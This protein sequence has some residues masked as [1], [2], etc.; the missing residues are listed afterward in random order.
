MM[1]TIA[2]GIGLAGAGFLFSQILNLVAYLVLVR[3]L[4]PRDFGLYAAGTLIT[5]IGGL[6]AESGMMAA[7][8]TRED[9]IDEAA[10]TAFVSLAITG[11]ALALGSLAISPLL[12][13]A[14][15]NSQV[16]TVA[17]V[18]SG[19]LLIR[20]LTIV[21]DALLQRRFSFARRA[22]V[23]PLGVVAYAAAAIPLAASG[24]GV[25]AMVGG[26]YASI[27]VEAVFS[28]LAAGFRPRLRHASVSL[29]R[30]LSSFTR[31]LVVGEVLR[32]VTIQIDTF[33]L[34]RVSGPAALGQYRN[35][36]M[37]AQQP[38]NAFG[39]V[40]AYVILPA[41]ARLASVPARL[42]VAA[43]RAFWVTH[44]AVVPVAAACLPL[45]VPVAVILLGTRWR[46]AGHAIAGLSGFVL[47]SILLSVSGELMKAMGALRL[48]LATH[49][50]WL[51]LVATTVVTASL[52]W[53]LVGVAVALSV[54]TCA[55]AVYTMVKIARRM[56]LPGHELLSGLA[57]PAVASAVMVGV[58]LLFSSASNLLHHSGA[59]GIVL[60]LVDTLI[61]AV[62]Y[63]ATLA[64]IDGPRRRAALALLRRLWGRFMAVEPTY[65]RSSATAEQYAEPGSETRDDQPRTAHAAPEG[66]HRIRTLVASPLGRYCLLAALGF[67]L[68][69][70]ETLRATH[71]VGDFW[72]HAATVR[73]LM[74][75]TT[76]PSNALLAVHS[77]SAFFSPYALLVAVAAKATGTGP[78]HELAVAGLLNYCLLAGG[79]WWF[80]RLFSERPQAPFYALLFL[81]LLWGVHPWEYS[82]FFD[83]RELGYGLAYPSTFA[84]AL[85]MLTAALWQRAVWRQGRAR[86]A[87]AAL[88]AVGVALVVLTHPVAGVATL[89]AIGAVSL[90]TDGR[91]SLALLA[92]T[93]VGA[94]V[95]CLI[96]P[97]YPILRLLGDQGVYDPSNEL[98]YQGWIEQTFPVFAAI[99]LFFYRTGSLHRAR[100]AIYCA[101]LLL[102]FIYGDVSGHWSDG[103][104]IAYLVL[105]AQIGLGDAAA[106]WEQRA[107]AH[108][109]R[110]PIFAVA[111]AMAIFAA[112]ELANM[113]DGFRGSLPGTG[114][115]EPVAY[116]GYRSAVN[117]LPP[118]SVTAAPLDS[119]IE[120]VVP[121][122]GG[123]L[124]STLRP[125]AFVADQRQ[126][127]Q[128]VEAFYSAR[129]SN[130]FRRQ[131]IARYH[132]NYVLVP[133]APNQRALASALRQ[134]GP[135]IRRGSMFDTLSV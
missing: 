42:A 44:T 38:G 95:L 75:H 67:I 20:A 41:F 98:M 25:W 73:E 96:W 99:G 116:A 66:Q 43:R 78:V 117:G 119:G 97:Y 59:V 111:M 63:C 70:L 86:L 112:L 109:R 53:G 9:R 68:V 10:S 49:V 118:D 87:L 3:L 121:V 30:E 93:V 65:V 127:Q 85:G 14:F 51:V 125:L 13:L 1:Q 79:V 131:V 54:S 7:L 92:G 115:P 103:R 4:T 90:T 16:G 133:T 17:A 24:A 129:T 135:V 58:M 114:S 33:M 113:A 74:L 2:R 104:E 55:T 91:R 134:L 21:P 77:P 82:G 12:G 126:R 46:A 48:Q 72:E 132:V 83:L 101:P 11:V 36:M 6:F 5:G 29:W 88:T 71:E 130:R 28:W 128:T 76:N 69:A 80:A 100:L 110:L 40:G 57:T 106:T 47:G 64:A 8:I 34:G 35:G 31:P 39:S 102:L 60:L 62:V 23:D 26:A 123:K 107:Q 84:T 56:G 105:G 50:V 122:Y 120:A 124:I 94:G 18:L 52:T 22:V 81:W 108:P 19:W 89:A 27:L 61:A 45:G 37:L 15:H 32:R